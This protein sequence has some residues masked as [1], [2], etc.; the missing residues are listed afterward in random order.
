MARVACAAAAKVHVGCITAD[1]PRTQDLSG[2]DGNE[3]AFPDALRTVADAA[4]TS[5]LC[6]G[7]NCMCEILWCVLL[8]HSWT[9]CGTYLS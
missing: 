7:V 5:I 1:V 4:S 6:G 2:H 3:I 9:E 8:L